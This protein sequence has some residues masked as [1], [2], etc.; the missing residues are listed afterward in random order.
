M[1]SNLSRSQRRTQGTNHTGRFS[2]ELTKLSPKDAK[3]LIETIKQACEPLSREELILAV[4]AT[5]GTYCEE[6]NMELDEA[7]S[8]VTETFGWLNKLKIS[9]KNVLEEVIAKE[10]RN[11][12]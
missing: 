1:G 11:I 12:Y 4:Y 10:R 6:M 5:F 7:L 8:Y 2:K 9:G 3:I